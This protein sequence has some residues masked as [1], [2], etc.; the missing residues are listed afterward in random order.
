MVLI[1]LISAVVIQKVLWSLGSHP[2]FPHQGLVRRWGYNQVFLALSV[3]H[4]LKPVRE[5]WVFHFPLL[6]R[7]EQ[8]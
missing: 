7:V 1:S 8:D 3:F 6:E 4:D 5:I 2:F